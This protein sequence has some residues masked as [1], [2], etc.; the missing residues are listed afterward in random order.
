MPRLDPP[1]LNGEPPCLKSEPGSLGSEMGEKVDFHLLAED[2]EDEEASLPV[3]FPLLLLDF[4]P[5][6]NKSKKPADVKLYNICFLSIYSFIFLP[7]SPSQSLPWLSLLSK[8]MVAIFLSIL[9]KQKH[10]KKGGKN[11]I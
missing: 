8:E 5:G 11:S 6:G 9:K 3:L 10:F 7:C 2:K 1:T 4:L